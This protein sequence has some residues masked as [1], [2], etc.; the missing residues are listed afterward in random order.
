MRLLMD[1]GVSEA[2]TRKNI[3]N[4]VDWLVEGAQSGDSLFFHYSGHGS[5]RP[6]KAAP[7]PLG[8]P[9]TIFGAVFRHCFKDR[10]KKLKRS[11]NHCVYC[12]FI[13]CLLLLHIARL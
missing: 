12:F 3:L 10:R 2:P 1:D 6:K 11:E 5:D 13:A 8:S 9:K 4:A 7:A